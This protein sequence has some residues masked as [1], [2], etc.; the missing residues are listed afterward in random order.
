VVKVHHA[1]EC[2][3]PCHLSIDHE[4]YVLARPIS[5]DMHLSLDLHMLVRVVDR[6]GFGQVI[7]LLCAMGCNEMVSIA[8]CVVDLFSSAMGSMGYVP[9]N[10]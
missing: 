10:Q 7:V 1:V 2:A 8:W 4:G 6:K 3:A 5:E 9:P